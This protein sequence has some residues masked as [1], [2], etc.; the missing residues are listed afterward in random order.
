MPDHS[1]NKDI[2]P[3]IQSKPPLMQLEAFKMGNPR[4]GLEAKASVTLNNM[5]GNGWDTLAPN[6]AAIC[7]VQGC[8]QTSP[9]VI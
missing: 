9:I 3:D 7:A 1:F 4:E 2:F 5:L 6:A 8:R